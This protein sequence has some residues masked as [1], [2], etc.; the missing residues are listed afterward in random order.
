MG[1]V[2]V[3]SAANSRTIDKLN[4][5]RSAEIVMCRKRIWAQMSDSDCEDSSVSSDNG[6]LS[7]GG[8]V[9]EAADVA[10]AGGGE[11]EEGSEAEEG[12][13]AEEGREAEEG[14]EAEE[15]YDPDYDYE[16]HYEDEED[17]WHSGWDSDA[18]DS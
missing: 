8:I 11:V 13:G 3:I 10:V 4:Q 2:A 7:A 15:V 14:G 6:D 18:E 12:S 17:W 5:E 9:I 16:A 1:T